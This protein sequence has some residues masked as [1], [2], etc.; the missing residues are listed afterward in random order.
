MLEITAPPCK[1]QAKPCYSLCGI[2]PDDTKVAPGVGTV[3]TPGT[4]TIN[5][6]IIVTENPPTS[7]MDVNHVVRKTDEEVARRIAAGN[8]DDFYQYSF[9]KA[10]NALETLVIALMRY[11]DGAFEES[12]RFT[13]EFDNKE[14]QMKF[15]GLGAFHYA[16]TLDARQNLITLVRVSKS[17]E[18]DDYQFKFKHS[19]FQQ[20]QQWEERKQI[21]IRNQERVTIEPLLS[22][23]DTVS[24]RFVYRKGDENVKRLIARYNKPGSFHEY[25]FDSESPDTLVIKE[26]RYQRQSNQPQ[27]Q[28][29]GALSM[30]DNPNPNPQIFTTI[31][32][33]HFYQSSN[34]CCQ[35]VPTDEN[36]T[37]NMGE[38][39][40]E[41]FRF[42]ANSAAYRFEFRPVYF[43]EI[44]EWW[45]GAQ[46]SSGVEPMDLGYFPQL[47][48]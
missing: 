45:N 15:F 48:M 46:A 33:F 23:R 31:L 1:P 18:K 3:A 28:P 14:C 4:N 2:M 44:M 43:E 41:L 11:E 39:S 21:F 35:V 13:F 37:Y 12:L 30:F 29:G 27:P 32:V 7:T 34:Q 19:D 38:N 36:Y 8:L 42:G 24:K 17:F 22:T 40:I 5:T 47:R 25:S 10:E 6:P 20:I 16:Y 9:E 26:I